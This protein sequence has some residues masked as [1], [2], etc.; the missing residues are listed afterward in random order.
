M[1][2]LAG[3]PQVDARGG[4]RRRTYA[5][6]LAAL[7]AVFLAATGLV[8]KREHDSASAQERIA[9]A[10]GLALHAAELRGVDPPMAWDLGVAAVK[11]HSDEQTRAG[12]TD[13]LLWGRGDSLTSGVSNP[14]ALSGDGRI[15]LTGD[16]DDE[17]KESVWDLKSWLDP[18]IVEKS[19]RLAVLKSRKGFVGSVALSFDGRTALAAGGNDDATIVWDLADPAKPSRLATLAVERTGKRNSDDINRVEAVTLSR[20]GRTAV[21]VGTNGDMTVWDLSVRSHPVRLSMTRAH[22]SPM[23]DLDLSADGRTAVT[24]DIDGVVTVWDL[25]DPSHPVRSVDL[26]QPA[27]AARETAMSA[28]GRVV[29][30]G[31]AHQVEIWN[32]GD[33][34]HPVRIAVF[35]IPLG[36]MYDM[37]LTPD[38]K[39]ALFAGASGSGLLWDLSNPSRPTRLAALHGYGQ[40]IDSV[41]L[42]ADGGVALTA[43]SNGA[44]L[45][46]LKKLAEIVA[47]PG[48]VACHGDQGTKISEEDW[49]RYANGADWSDYQQE[50]SDHLYIC[51]IRPDSP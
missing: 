30:V 17:D 4:T 10:R 12:L 40:E 25:A 45:W 43:G 14:V 33:R 47:D 51:D 28:D 29:L 44:S 34:R 32:L 20:D 2:D 36:D 42:S 35:D 7:L 31:S 11:I 8:W 3:D 13:T 26:D 49:A 23:H 39:R 6:T 27:K 19:D 22:T 1:N 9:L 37:A 15:A 21:I 24:L 18:K 48:R 46:N 38:G 41:A 50:S 16:G 5:I